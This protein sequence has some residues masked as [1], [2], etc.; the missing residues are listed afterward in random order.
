M[1]LEA[2]GVRGKGIASRL[3]PYVGGPAPPALDRSGAAEADGD[4][5]RLDD[6]RDVALIVGYGEHSFEPFRVLQDVD[7]IERHVSLRVGLTGVARVLSEIVAE[8][9]YFFFHRRLLF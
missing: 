6:H 1:R 2:R 7:V 4:F 3:T 8:D 5:A 9:Q